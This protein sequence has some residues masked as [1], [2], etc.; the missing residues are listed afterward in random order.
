MQIKI[1]LNIFATKKENVFVII[2]IFVNKKNNYKDI[3]I[4]FI[5]YNK[6]NFVGIARDKE[7]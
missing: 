6:W 5:K 3:G 1:C 7:E 2:Y 4:I